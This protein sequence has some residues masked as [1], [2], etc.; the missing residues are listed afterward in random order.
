MPTDQPTPADL[1]AA[2]VER[3]EIAYRRAYETLAAE[4]RLQ[5]VWQ[6]PQTIPDDLRDEHGR[7][8]LLD[9]LTALVNGRAALLNATTA[10]R[11]R[12][13]SSFAPAP[14]RQP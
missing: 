3:L 10:A 14:W 13:V 2:D 9:A 1:L 6:S 11:P 5:G 4:L 7:F 8:L 12:N